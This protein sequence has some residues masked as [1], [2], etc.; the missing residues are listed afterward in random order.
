MF[1]NILLSYKSSSFTFYLCSKEKFSVKSAQ[2]YLIKEK[3]SFQRAFFTI[4]FGM[5]LTKHKVY[6][7]ETRIFINLNL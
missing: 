5:K 4:K 7:E 6:R 2:E 3:I 1:S